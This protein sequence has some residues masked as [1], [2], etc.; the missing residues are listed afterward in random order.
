MYFAAESG[1]TRKRHN[2]LAAQREAV[3]S[4]D[5]VWLDER[6]RPVP[7]VVGS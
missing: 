3:V 5:G 2:E 6:W 4:D 1:L 7:L